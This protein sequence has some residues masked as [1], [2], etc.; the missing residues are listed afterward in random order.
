MKNVAPKLK[1]EEYEENFAEIHPPLSPNAAV[2]EADR[3]LFCYDAPCTRACPT[4]IDIPGFIKK[5]STGNLTGSAKTIL[6]SNWIALTCAKACPVEVLCEGACVYHAR[7]E[8]PI[9][10]GRLQRYAIDWYFGRGLPPLFFPAPANG[11][12]VGVIGAGA[13]GLACSAEAALLGY[14]VTVYDA[15]ETPGGASHRI[16]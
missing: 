2:V 12:S 10:I 9:Q 5:I 16:R 11:K 15:N 1:P 4:H 7:G 13:S 6:R 8:R 3:C 14:D